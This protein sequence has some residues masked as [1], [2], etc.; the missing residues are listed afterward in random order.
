[1]LDIKQ[2]SGLLEA[3]QYLLQTYADI[4]SSST[5][6]QIHALIRQNELS[7]S[8]W[9]LDK[10]EAAWDTI[11]PTEQCDNCSLFKIQS[12]F[13]TSR[14]DINI[15]TSCR[16]RRPTQEKRGCFLWPHLESYLM[17]KTQTKKTTVSGVSIN[18]SSISS[19]VWFDTQVLI[20]CHL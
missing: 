16:F 10:T 3:E 5:W 1:M 19:S 8:C 18:L 15:S 4:G 17:P 7:P 12:F 13:T 6:Q 11:K 14:C 2:Q 9:L 20:C